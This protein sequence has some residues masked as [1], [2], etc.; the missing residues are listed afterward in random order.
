MRPRQKRPGIPL[1]GGGLGSRLKGEKGMNSAADWVKRSRI[2]ETQE[3]L[4]ATKREA[5]LAAQVTNS[6]RACM[7]LIRAQIY[8]YI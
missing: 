1:Q 4:M 6:R 3:T 2:R 8:I 5:L 7:H